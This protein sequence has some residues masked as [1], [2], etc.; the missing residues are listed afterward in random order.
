MEKTCQSCIHW[1][2]ERKG[3][4]SGFCRRSPPEYND[5]YQKY[6]QPHFRGDIWCSKHKEADR[7]SPWETISSNKEWEFTWM[8]LG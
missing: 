5:D 7:Q 3:S 6:M 1:E 8:D 2:G 4:M